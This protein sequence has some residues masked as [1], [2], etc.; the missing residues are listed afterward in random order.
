M[1]VALPSMLQ[2]LFRY[3]WRALACRLCSTRRR[4]FRDRVALAL[5]C[6]PSTAR[7]DVLRLE[8]ANW[9]P[10]Y[11]RASSSNENKMSD[12]GRGRASIGKEVWKSSQKR[13]VQRSAVRFIAWVDD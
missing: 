2:P 13:I 11:E 10:R 7:S 4:L 12:G 5:S 6:F 1:P 8:P 9:R 3:A